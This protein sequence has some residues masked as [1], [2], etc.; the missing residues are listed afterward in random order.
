MNVIK[1]I[2]LVGFILLLGA[3]TN[4]KIQKPIQTEER[5][6]YSSKGFALIYS[7]SLYTQGVIDKKLNNEVKKDMDDMKNEIEEL[8]SGIHIINE[9]LQNMKNEIYE[10]MFSFNFKK[11]LN[12]DENISYIN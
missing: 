6:F 4:Y 5:R 8:K 3:C 9:E 12:F 10:I 11:K 2:I 7:D 1:K